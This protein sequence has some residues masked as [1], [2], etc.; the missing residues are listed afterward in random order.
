[1]SKYYISI[2]QIAEFLN[3]SKAVQRR[4]VK[5]QITPNKLLIPWYQQAKGALK[6]YFANIDVYEPIEVAIEKLEKKIPSNNRQ[7]IDKN[8]SIEALKKVTTIEKPKLLRDISYQ[9]IKSNVKDLNINDVDIRVAPDVIFKG[10]L[11]GKIVYGAVKFHVSK[12]KPFDFEQAKLVSTLLYQ[13][14][15]ENIANA[16]EKVLPELCLCYDVFGERLVP[17]PRN[18]SKQLTVIKGLCNEIKEVW[19]KSA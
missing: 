9:L 16:T 7:K 18:T 1:M 12:T 13:F 3:S 8:V 6:K 4:I 15:K 2:N 19:P 14:M 11:D 17:A 5:Q 10:T